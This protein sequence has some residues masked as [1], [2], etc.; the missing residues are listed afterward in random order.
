VGRFFLMEV[1]PTTSMSRQSF[2]AD[3]EYLK[4]V[5]LI[6]QHGES[7]DDERTG[8]GTISIFSPPKLVFPN[9]AGNFPLL[10]TKRM[11]WKA[12][13]AELIWFLKGQTD[14]KILERQ[15]VNIWKDNATR[16]FLDRRGLTDYPEGELGPI[17]GWNWRRWGC[18]Y[19]KKEKL[20]HQERMLTQEINRLDVDVAMNGDLDNKTLLQL[21]G[22]RAVLTEMR[23]VVQRKI[24]KIPAGID[25]LAEAIRLIHEDPGSRRII[26]SA[27]NVTDLPK[28]AL[29]ACHV[30]YQFHVSPDGST[31]N[32]LMTQR[33]ADVALGL[34]FN[35]AS[36][37]LLLTIVAHI[38]GKKAG[39]LSISLGDAHIYRKHIDIIKTQLDREPKPSPKVAISRDLGD[40]DSTEAHHIFL[41]NYQ[42]HPRLAFP[43]VV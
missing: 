36:Y 19:G 5:N 17:Y 7:R 24:T 6:L 37:A 25:Q 9:V 10:T 43:F 42:C 16:E 32:M 28:M 31:L 22:Q 2:N 26:V 38:T 15:D 34:P 12:I 3:E 27:W 29:P 40:I 39:T 1:T 23:Q 35:I 4:L 13:V 11:A 41:H 30:M 18:P 33:S 8:D 21:Q 14:S 20:Q